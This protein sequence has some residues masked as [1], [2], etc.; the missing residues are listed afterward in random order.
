MKKSLLVL[1]ILFFASS[2]LSISLHE[3]LRSRT[4]GKT[5]T[6]TKSGI[7]TSTRTSNKVETKVRSKAMLRATMREIISI[8]TIPAQDAKLL[9]SFD[10][11]YPT[12]KMHIIQFSIT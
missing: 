12:S 9:E 2:V 7:K 6:R 5:S 4:R 1:T 11:S 10:E 8:L 3:R